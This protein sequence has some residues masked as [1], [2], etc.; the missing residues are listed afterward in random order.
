MG[1]DEVQGQKGHRYL[2]LVD[3]SDGTS[4]RLLHIAPERTVRSLRSL[5]RML[6]K[7]RSADLQFVWSARWQPYGKVIA[8]KAGQAVHVLDRCHSMAK[9]NKAIDAVRAAETKRL[10][11]DG[12][13]Q[14]LKHARWCL[15]KRPENRTE[16]QTVQLAE[17]W[18]YH[19]RTVRAYLLR[20]DF[21]RFGQYRAPYGAACLLT[22][23]CRRVMRWRIEPMK[24]VAR[25]LDKQ[26]ELIRNWFT[27][28]GMLSAGMVEGLHDN[29]KRTMKKS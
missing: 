12:L 11:R 4:R 27:A 7:T 19:V 2:T 25:T 3:Q 5:F 29:V 24:K 28:Q 18:K 21:P 1:V 20:E 23:G 9:R 26:G 10:Q 22:E 17:V 14:V 8:Q 16:K 6:G 13:E 15:W